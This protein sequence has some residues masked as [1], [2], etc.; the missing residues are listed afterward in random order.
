MNVVP[1]GTSIPLDLLIIDATGGVIGQSPVVLVQRKSDLAYWN[2][3][4]GFTATPTP[5]ALAEV[6]AVNQ[7]GL[8]RVSFN[9]QGGDTATNTYIAYYTN[10]NP[11]FPGNA[12]DEILFSDIEAN[13]NTLAIAQAVAS[14]ILV[15]PA[16]PIDSS[17]I[18]SQTLLVEVDGHVENIEAN[19]ATQSSLDAY[20]VTINAKL[21]SILAA[22]QPAV[23][24]SMV[25]FNIL[26]GS[27]LP[28]PDVFVTIKNST[29]A[30]TVAVGRTDTNGQ[31][32]VGL[33]GTFLI[34]ETFQVLFY[35]PFYT[36]GT[37]PYTLV[38]TGNQT[39]NIT[40]ASFQPVSNIPSVCTCYCYMVDATGVPVV[41][42]ILRAKLVSNFPFTPG[43][44]MLATKEDIVA[45]TDVSGFV[46]LNLIQ[47]A[48]YE[49][50]APALYITLTNFLVPTA[51]SLDLSTQ[52]Q[53][54]S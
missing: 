7:P 50:T 12:V 42:E 28:I 35:K 30:I 38:V 5:V 29:G 6:D 19:M 49:I 48:T 39:V 17:D 45:K 32:V 10:P 31:F 11:S 18:A 20:M 15:N 14:K 1:L 34:P 8:Y 36:F 51:A 43:T 9:S 23:G 40:G 4:N 2:G 24:S 22:V 44:G 27:S 46:S 41:G 54:N 37:Q 47:G 33:P 25:T 21:D 13:V 16:I 52:L 3:T 26:D 53:Y